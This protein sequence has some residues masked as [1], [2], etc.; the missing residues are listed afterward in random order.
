MKRF[1]LTLFIAI[2][3]SFATGFYIKNNNA[4]IGDRIIGITILAGAFI[5]VPSFLYYRRN[6]TKLR[7]FDIIPKKQNSDKK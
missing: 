3:I 5:L 7:N 4:L 6:K 1:I 2:V